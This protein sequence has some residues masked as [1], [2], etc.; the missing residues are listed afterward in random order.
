MSDPQSATAAQGAGAQVIP[1]DQFITNEFYPGFRAEQ[2]RS[3]FVIEPLLPFS[4]ED[5][6]LFWVMDSIHFGHGIVPGNVSLCE[7]AITWGPQWAAER[8]GLPPGRGLRT[9]LGGTFPYMSPITVTDP[10]MLEW[11]A[12]RFGRHLAHYLQ[13]FDQIWGGY[14]QELDA[15]HEHF[16]ALDPQALT[17]DA[18]R[19]AIH[20]AHTYYGRAWEIHFEAMYTLLANYLSFYGLAA[21]LGLDPSQN[22]RY[23][24]G[25]KT[26]YIET[27]EGLWK[28]ALRAGEL[29]VADALLAGD[30][31]TARS[32]VEHLPNGAIWCRELDAFLDVY[33]WRIEENCALNL[34]P[35]I[36]DP[37]PAL[38]AI[39]AFL[40]REEPHDF[41]AA[42]QASIAQRDEAIEEAR[43]KIGNK[44]DIERFDAA[45][46]SNQ[47]MNFAWWNDDH[48]F[49]IDKRAQVPTH[50][51]TRELGRRLAD[52]G[53]IEA[54]DDVYFLFRAEVFAG[55]DDS[56]KWRDFRAYVPDRKAYYAEWA[57]KL[58]SLPRVLGTI[59]N[60]VMDP[61]LI[62]IFGLSPHYLN[63]AT[64]GRG[65]RLNE[66]RGVAASRGVAEGRARVVL[67]SQELRELQAGEILVCHGTD[68]EW[69]PVFGYIKACVCDAGG[70][71]THAAIISRE[72]GIPC[73]V[74]T[75][76]ATSNIRT[77]DRVRVDGTTGTVQVF[78]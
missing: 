56:A 15:A 35:W 26:K 37:A 32:R 59:P 29:N 11:R 2:A 57:K 50:R 13:H 70:S 71:L 73:V 52:S 69:T 63:V 78:Q 51:M 10:W 25:K 65:K 30:L 68:P 66:L 17:A 46:A 67:S 44:S 58:P 8:V 49:R 9:R 23:L 4:K 38:S 3:P 31:A 72:Y 61:V 54:P 24:A 6:K 12:G 62:E 1:V 19:R 27:D 40:T 75:G 48:N 64:Q 41:D 77:G 5:E 22:S 76:L 33:G 74:G 39:R 36:D 43:R 45:L 7:Q 60:A 14:E 34:K 55:L 42:L 53:A 18:L 28:L 16:R 47:A 20:D 21:E